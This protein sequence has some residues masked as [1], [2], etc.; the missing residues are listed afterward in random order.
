MTKLRDEDLLRTLRAHPRA[1]SAELCRL[2]GGINRST[3]ARALRSLGD[4]VISRGGS[5]RTRYALRRAL[6]GSH[7]SLPLYRIDASG[8]GHDVAQLDPIYPA[9]SALNFAE[10]FPWPLSPDEMADGWFEGLPYPLLDMRPQGYIGRH[11]ARHHALDLG[12]SDNPEQWS[13]D[14]ILHVLS[15]WGHDQPGDLLLGDVAYR[16]FLD[17]R[18]EGADGFLRDEQIAHA[19]PELAVAAVAAGVPASS[20]GGEFPKFTAGRLTAGGAAH[21]IVKFSGADQSPAVRRWS[22]LLVCEHL[23]LETL[24]GLPGV[25]AAQSTIHIFAGRSFLEVRRFDR[26]GAWGR[27]PVCT[28]ASI[29]GAMLG[30]G[31]SAWPKAALALQRAGWLMAADTE[32]VALLWWFGKLIGNTD[33]HAG[34]LAFEPSAGTGFALAPAYDML[35]MLYAPLRGGEVPERAFVPS[36]PLPAEETTWRRAKEIAVRYWQCCAADRRIGADFRR[37]CAGNAA[38]LAHAG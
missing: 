2:L 30:Q 27:S 22:D 37:I 38:V 33:M 15:L 10:P 23:A 3:L 36:V 13:D 21:V 8:Q 16:R 34:N 26:H 5:R 17:V 28:L 32:R 29:D 20:A 19:Y 25:A 18:T 24:R 31:A 9:G 35:P 11:F 14:D 4:C 1:G 7:A 6:R 12:V